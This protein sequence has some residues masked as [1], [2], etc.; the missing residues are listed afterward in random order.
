MKKITITITQDGESKV[1]ASGFTGDECVK[2]TA[3]IEQALGAVE[4]ERVR[5][6]ERNT[7][8]VG[9]YATTGNGGGK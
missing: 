5:K 6:L 8:A 9:K 3:P 4:G 7:V 1:E 2:E